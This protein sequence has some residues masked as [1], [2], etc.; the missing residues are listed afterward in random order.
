MD[1]PSKYSFAR[2]AFI[3]LLSYATLIIASV[4]LNFLLKA[5]TNRFVPDAVDRFNFLAD[6]STIIGF[7]AAVIIAF[8]IFFYLSY[9]SNTMLG[10]G[11]MRHDTGVR[12]W[13]IYLT[14]VVV[15]LIIIWQ[16]TAL[17]ISFLNGT[18]ATRFLIHT[19]IT[20]LIAFAILGYQW[21]HLKFFTGATKPLGLGFRAFEWIVLLAVVGSVVGTF[22]MVA[23]PSERR[24][25]RLDETRVNNLVSIQ[26]AISSFYYG[27]KDGGGLAGRMRLPAS[28]DELIT[29]AR[30]YISRSDTVD[31][32]TQEPYEYKI[33]SYNRYELCAAFASEWTQSSASDKGTASLTPVSGHQ[34]LFYHLS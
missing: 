25:K 22:F 4:S 31:P 30:V 9:L 29:D 5:I 28:F 18:L 8:P 32:E 23:S 15:I 34:E 10:R 24:L 1:N 13:L 7:L 3:Y 11:K 20:L 21:W 17:V 27:N 12:N 19:F 6:D 2:D 26:D 14:L 16:V 33:L